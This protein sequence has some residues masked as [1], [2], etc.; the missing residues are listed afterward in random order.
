M[1]MR[2]EGTVEFVVGDVPDWVRDWM[3]RRR[4]S[5]AGA[6]PDENEAKPK[7]SIATSEVET[8]AA[9]PDP[10]A[11]ARAA[12]ARERN[13]Q[14]RE[15][16][17]RS[18]LDE[19]DVWLSDQVER[20]IATFVAQSGQACKL[21]AQRLVDAKAAGLATRLESIPGKLFSLPEARRSIAAVEE[22]GQIYLLAGAY[23]R[24][25][26]LPA[27]L[28]ADVRQAVGWTTAR[29]ALLAD[30]SALR[31]RG[32]WRVIGVL[33][34]IQPDRLRRIETWLWRE[35]PETA[36]RVGLLLDFVPVA[37]GASAGGYIVGDR[38]EAELVFYP[39]ST[40]LR[41]LVASSSGGA[42]YSDSELDLPDDRLDVAYKSYEAAMRTQ[43]WLGTWPLSFRMGRLRRAGKS[44]FLCDAGGGSIGFP[45]RPAQVE[46]AAPLASLKAIDGVGLWDGYHFTLCWAQTEL[47]RWVNG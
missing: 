44:L 10:K 46:L 1:W 40:P 37:T 23:R 30:E 36:P 7:V 2:A 22:L 32:I 5:G 20:G 45:I 6:K 9:A 17:I 3:S 11:E 18:G 8:N 35:G 28:N 33:T 25:G 27:E 4:H 34:E 29:E 13:R 38:L 21:I 43:P 26:S 39:S 47:G 16:A 24:Q 12:A 15:A 31:V 41:A 14:E 19:L 42:Q